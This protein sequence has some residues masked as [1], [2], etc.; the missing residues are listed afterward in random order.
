[1]AI[2]TIAFFALNGEEFQEGGRVNLCTFFSWHWGGHP[3][4]E[5]THLVVFVPLW[6]VLPMCEATNLCVCVCVICVLSPH[7]NG[8]MQTQ[9]GLELADFL[10]VRRIDRRV[11]HIQCLASQ[12]SLAAHAWSH[13]LTLPHALFPELQF[14]QGFP[15]CYISRYHLNSSC[16]GPYSCL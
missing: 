13:W 14:F 9:V 6:L 11:M 10:P 3:Q 4:R 1:M 16:E 15:S 5:G 8:A 12:S 7:S 2:C